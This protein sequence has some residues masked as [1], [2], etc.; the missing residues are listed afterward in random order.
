[1][2]AKSKLQQIWSAQWRKRDCLHW[3]DCCFHFLCN[4]FHICS[5]LTWQVLLR[6][7]WSDCQLMAQHQNRPISNVPICC[8]GSGLFPACSQ[9]QEL[10]R[11]LWPLCTAASGQFLQCYMLSKEIQELENGSITSTFLTGAKPFLLRSHHRLGGGHLRQRVGVGGKKRASTL[12]H[13]YGD[14][15]YPVRWKESMCWISS[16]LG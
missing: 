1:M 15:N 2:S 11:K 8:L 7:V 16:S 14:R 9:S 10:G 3:S 6:E 5:S 12:A 4:R 13:L